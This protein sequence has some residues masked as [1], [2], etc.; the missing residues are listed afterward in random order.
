VR[1]RYK[2]CPFPRP[3]RCARLPPFRGPTNGFFLVTFVR[4][5]QGLRGPYSTAASRKHRAVHVRA[6]TGNFLFSPSGR[7]RPRFDA[8]SLTLY[9]MEWVLFPRA[10]RSTASQSS[11][12]PGLLVKSVALS[13]ATISADFAVSER[14][15]SP[16]GD[17]SSSE[18]AK[19]GV[20]RGYLFFFCF[21]PFFP[22]YCF[23]ERAL[24][25]A[26]LT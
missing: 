13:P 19:Q 8:F 18:A 10:R 9:P 2:K 5:R 26:F 7:A 15:L 21:E 17:F 24:W 1:F 12:G 23:P 22:P 25:A 14:K 4:K 3:W 6:F 20:L 11:R 16:P